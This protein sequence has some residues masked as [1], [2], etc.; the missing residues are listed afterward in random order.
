MYLRYLI[1]RFGVLVIVI[2]ASISVNFMIPRLLPGDPVEQKLALM[3]GQGSGYVGDVKAIADSYRAKFGLDQPVWKQYLAYW[4]D[5]L[6]FDLGVSLDQYPARVWDIIAA[7]LP[8]TVGLLATATLISFVLGSLL[9]GLMAWPKT[10]RAVLVFVPVFMVIS[11]TPYFL[12]GMALVLLF[13]IRFRLFPVAQAY[14]FGATFEFGLKRVLDI[15]HHA[16]LPALSV[17]IPGIGRWALGMRGMM[18]SVL[19][20]DYITLAEA[21]GLPERRVFLWYGMRTCLLPQVTRL[22]LALGYV[23]SGTMLVEVTF[24]YPGI[25]YRL[26]QAVGAKDYFLIQ[27]IVLLLILS[28][29]IAMFLVDLIYPLIDPR[30]TYQRR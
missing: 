13:A 22:M 21:K 2:V 11:S 17:V 28:I 6:H 27:G 18:I 16:A 5:I 15:L 19:G 1:R 7:A 12:L 4:D 3:A 23:V 26:F 20:E 14:S 9:G 30:I 29:A 24:A 8:W 25:G 10:P